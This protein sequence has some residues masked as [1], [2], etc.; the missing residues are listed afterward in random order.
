MS[1]RH[2]HKHTHKHTDSSNQTVPITVRS[3]N[4]TLT[5]AVCVKQGRIGPG[6]GGLD[7]LKICRRDQSLL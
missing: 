1:D 2:I 7:L 3:F 4:N 5:L 6:V